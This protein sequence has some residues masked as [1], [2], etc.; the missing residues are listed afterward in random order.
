MNDIV[1]RTKIEDLEEKYFHRVE[2][3]DIWMLCEDWEPKFRI[4][5]VAQSCDRWCWHMLD[6]DICMRLNKTE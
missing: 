3:T 6:K 4:T 2:N 5:V 1:C